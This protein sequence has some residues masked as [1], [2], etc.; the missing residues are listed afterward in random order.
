R[1]RPHPDDHSPHAG[2]DPRVLERC[3]RRLGPCR[4]A[5]AAA[6]REDLLRAD[7]GA[8]DDDDRRLRGDGR[9]PVLRVLRGH[10]HPMYF[11]IGSYGTGQR[12]YAAV[13]FLLY[14]LLGGLLMLVAVIALYV[15]SARG[16][17]PGT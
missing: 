6:Q 4:A 9:L 3:R 16:G 13:K 2:G 14:S 7:A 12:Q 11:M 5:A 17:H 8:R 1:A 10:A 15:Y